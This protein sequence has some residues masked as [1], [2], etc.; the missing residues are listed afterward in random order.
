MFSVDI[1]DAVGLRRIECTE[2]SSERG[3]GSRR[4]EIPR[5]AR[6]DNV[7]RALVA[8]SVPPF[9]RSTAHPFHRS[10]VPPFHR[11]FDHGGFTPTERE[12]A[13]SWPRCSWRSPAIASAAASSGIFHGSYLPTS[14]AG[15]AAETCA[16]Q[17]AYDLLS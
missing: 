7:V 10:T 16:L 14:F 4:G 13:I 3:E 11:H 12:Y 17:C 9:H 15:S 8:F 1:R 5:F 2:S 6:D